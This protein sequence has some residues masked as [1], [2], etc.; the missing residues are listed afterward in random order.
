MSAYNI[1]AEK[2]KDRLGADV[3][4]GLLTKSNEPAPDAAAIDAACDAKILEAEADLHLAA[5]VYYVV[6]IVASDTATEAEAAAL[7]LSLE[8]K[9]LDLASYK[10]AQ[11]KP[12]VLNSGDKALYSG[13]STFSTC[14]S[15]R[16]RCPSGRC[17]G[18][19][20][21]TS[22]WPCRS[23]R[24]TSPTRTRARRIERV[25]GGVE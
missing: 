16:F 2:L 22:R 12:H 19:E 9:I 20:T 15:M 7:A 1:T 14:S 23:S 3:I 17:S 24:S 18:S 11:L 4:K 8:G 21:T 13:A 25:T 6:P 10:M 5:G